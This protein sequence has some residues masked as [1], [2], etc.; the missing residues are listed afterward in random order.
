MWQLSKRNSSCRPCVRMS[1]LRGKS[2]LSFRWRRFRGW[3]VLVDEVVHCVRASAI[4]LVRKAREV[5]ERE[6]REI[7]GTIG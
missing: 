4:C 2:N 7:C 1:A 5:L 6:G 3:L